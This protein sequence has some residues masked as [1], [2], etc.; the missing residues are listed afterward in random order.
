M[1]KSLARLFTRDA[2]LVT[3]NVG[4]EESARAVGPH[5]VA[6]LEHA[7]LSEHQRDELVTALL[8]AAT[9]ATSLN[10]ALSD[11]EEGPSRR[12][13]SRWL[14]GLDVAA[15]EES[16]NRELQKQ[17]A[18]R[19]P[20]R[21]IIGVDLT[22]VPY[23]GEPHEDDTELK[24]GPAKSGTTW[25]HAYATAYVC[26]RNRRYTFL[27]HFV[28]KDETPTRA[29][30]W[31]LDAMHR[32]GIVPRLVLA[33]KGFATRD[34]VMSMKNRRLAFIMP[35]PARGRRA[36]A[37]ARGKGSYETTYEINGESVRVAV[38]IKRN[39]RRNAHAK[40]HGKKPGNQYFAYI[41]HGLRATPKNIDRLYRLRGGI[42][43]S[44]KLNNQA[45]SRTSSRRPAVRLLCFAI[46]F[47]LQNAW[48]T[49]AWR[50]SAPTRGQQGRR[51]APGFFTLRRYLRIVHEWTTTHLGLDVNV[52]PL[53][54]AEGRR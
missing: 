49:L 7:A 23:H 35:L 46:G 47:L 14:E 29:L 9:R 11:V 45:R 44:Y 28:R 39:A 17:A 2:R 43:S 18:K 8:R 48:V 54:S 38:V 31:L 37:L 42:E 34:A 41:V 36:K 19:L 1:V 20:R 10:D 52:T 30:D 24:R 6:V 15:L 13:A 27:V 5:V 12:S 26:A 16:A 21:P 33:D 22:L 25:F 32:E 53:P 4:P 50:V 3:R 51:R 40:Y